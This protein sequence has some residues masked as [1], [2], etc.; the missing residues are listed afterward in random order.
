[1]EWIS[2]E[3]VKTDN[4]GLRLYGYGF[5]TVGGILD[6]GDDAEGPSS[7]TVDCQSSREYCVQ[8]KCSFI[9][10]CYCFRLNIWLQFLGKRC[11]L[12]PEELVPNS[13]KHSLQLSWNYNKNTPSCCHI[14]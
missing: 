13:A 8:V 5:C 1:M 12:F 10:H 7:R 3:L 9:L 14:L 4:T 2:I 6:N 11:S